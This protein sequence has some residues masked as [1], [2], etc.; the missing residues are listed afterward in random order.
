[1]GEV[2]ALRSSDVNEISR[3]ITVS[4]SLDGANVLTETKG[5]E[6]RVVP[7]SERLWAA[8]KPLDRTKRH[9]M[10]RRDGDGP[11]LYCGTRRG[12]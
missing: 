10:S 6:R 12:S 3:E 11:L 9:V 4:R 5:W 7:I 1:M 8:L 2:C